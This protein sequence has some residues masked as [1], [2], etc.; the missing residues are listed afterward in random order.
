MS[1]CVRRLEAR[2]VQHNTYIIH[3]YIY[4]HIQWKDLVGK[5][6]SGSLKPDEYNS[7][8]FTVSNL[9]MFGVSQV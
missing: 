4:I 3:T 8:T 1:Y 2:R 5:A 6:K 7:G 9:G